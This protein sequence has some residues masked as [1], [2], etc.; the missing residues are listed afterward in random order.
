VKGHTSCRSPSIYLKGL[1]G[2]G[3][4][5]LVREAL[6]QQYL[7]KAQGLHTYFCEGKFDLLKSHRPFL[8]ITQAINLLCSKVIRR[9]A[10]N[11]EKLLK[12]RRNLEQKVDEED[13]QIFMSLLPNLQQLFMAEEAEIMK[14]SDLLC[15]LSSLEWSRLLGKSADD[16]SSIASGSQSD[17]TAKVLRQGL[18][19]FKTTLVQLLKLLILRDE[20]LIL[21]LDDLQ[22][23]NDAS[24]FEIMEEILSKI[25]P[26]K[27]LLIGGYCSNKVGDDHLLTHYFKTLNGVEPTILT[28][29]PVDRRNGT[30][31]IAMTLQ[32]DEE[33]YL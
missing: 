19:R 8:A 9:H 17:S 12:I 28:L 30:Q 1:S 33:E 20:T 23:V 13:L 27:C 6:S 18:I 25:H 32:C 14:S 31:Y 10:Q 15:C 2:I 7:E 5:A 21:F 26:T 24:T 29:E 16:N 4:S 22:W 3:K 11:V